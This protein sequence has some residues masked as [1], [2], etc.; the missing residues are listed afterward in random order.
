MNSNEERV[1]QLEKALRELLDAIPGE[2][3]WDASGNVIEELE[4]AANH[5]AKLLEAENELE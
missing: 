1:K 3:F 2:A 4:S 5:A